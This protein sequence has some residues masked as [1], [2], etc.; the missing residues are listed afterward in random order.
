MS[1]S[2]VKIILV[3]GLA[4][5]VYAQGYSSAKS[6]YLEISLSEKNKL[7]LE[8]ETEFEKL[9]SRQKELEQTALQYRND[10]KRIS[11]HADRLRKQFASEIT[12][13]SN[14]DQS[15]VTVGANGRRDPKMAATLRIATDL[16]EERDRIALQY[17]ELRKSC[18]VH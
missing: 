17:N 1:L 16:I 14:H 11:A 5:G 7:V 10:A 18:D 13:T 2:L 12:E 8:Y 4:A 15:V 6:K 3:L 9:R